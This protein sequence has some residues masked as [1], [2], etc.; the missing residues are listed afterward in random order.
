[1]GELPA[2]RKMRHYAPMTDPIQAPLSYK[3]DLVRLGA[4]PLPVTVIADE[5]ACAGIAAAFGLPAIAALRGEF[6]LSSVRNPGAADHATATLVLNATVIQTCVV[7]LEPFEQTISERAALLMLTES[8]AEALDLD[9]APID[10]EAPDEIVAN[11][12][13]VDLGAVLTEQL[14]LALDPYP[15]KPGVATPEE[16][17]A[18]RIGPFSALAALAAKRGNDEPQ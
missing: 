17:A 11:G 5:A 7:T 15:R 12:T 8:Q 13:M 4:A 14:A 10:P 16:P 9:Q 6:V 18:P 1:M 3:V 2:S